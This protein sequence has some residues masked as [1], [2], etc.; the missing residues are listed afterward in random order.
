MK[1][2]ILAIGVHPDD[3]ELACSGTL[4]RHINA[5]YSVALLDLTEGELGTRGTPKLRFEEAQKAADLMGAIAREN[6]GMA[7]GFF[8][9]NEENLRKI[10]SVIRRFR[11]EIVIANAL[12]DRHP[13]HGRAASL[14]ADACFFS[15]L[16][17]IETLSNDGSI[18]DVWRPRAVY[19]SIQDYH[20]TPDFVVDISQF[21]EKKM[22]LVR[23]FRSQF[24][25]PESTE[26]DSPISG[27][28]FLEFLYARAR[29]FGRP[30]GYQFAEGFRATRLTGVKNLFDLD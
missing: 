10:I 17:K 16:R 30:A 14:A 8:L 19:H 3:I 20:M 22:E 13:D 27:K 26:P 9:H 18:Q 11:P 23:A 24:Y 25:D 29:E 4:L 15:G 2:D 5:G 6:A 7:D 21:I 28:D 12:A 1:V